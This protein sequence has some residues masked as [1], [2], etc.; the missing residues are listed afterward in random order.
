MIGF[1]RNE[2]SSLR[3]GLRMLANRW[4]AHDESRTNER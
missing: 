3:R 1:K 4:H 2:N